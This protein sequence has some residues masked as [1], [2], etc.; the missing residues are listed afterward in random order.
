MRQ[1]TLFLGRLTS[2]ERG[3]TRY[4]RYAINPQI[5]PVLGT[6]AHKILIIGTERG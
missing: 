5:L 1:R 6:K 3:K 4:H 2:E